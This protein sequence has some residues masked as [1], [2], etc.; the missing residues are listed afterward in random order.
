VFI[1]LSLLYMI[2]FFKKLITVGHRKLIGVFRVIASIFMF[3]WSILLFTTTGHISV[4]E[5]QGGWYI[6]IVLEMIFNITTLKKINI[7]NKS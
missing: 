6:Y 4:S 3:T 7:A 5:V 2:I 1:S